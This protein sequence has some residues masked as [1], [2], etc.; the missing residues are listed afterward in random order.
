MID[1]WPTLTVK[2]GKDWNR[3]FVLRESESAPEPDVI[4]KEMEQKLIFWGLSAVHGPCEKAG[5]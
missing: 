3:Q 2:W 1:V 5:C 4:L